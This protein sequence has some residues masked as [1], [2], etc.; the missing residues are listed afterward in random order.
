MYKRG[1]KFAC[2]DCNASRVALTKHYKETGKEHVWRS[3]SSAD[4]NSRIISQKG[5]SSGSGRKFV[6]K[7][8][9]EATD[10]DLVW[11]SS[12]VFQFVDT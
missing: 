11:C 7:L 6:V 2:R 1:N 4:K 8:D 9:E 5:R 10:V 3:L 12:T